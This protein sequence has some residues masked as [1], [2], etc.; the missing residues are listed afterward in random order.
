M[1]KLAGVE[2]AALGLIISISEF[3]LAMGPVPGTDIGFPKTGIQL[4]ST[5]RNAFWNATLAK[6][7]VA[8]AT[9]A[10]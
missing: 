3:R 8:R 6:P 10:A 9:P 2:P 1:D 7:V 4:I 5:L